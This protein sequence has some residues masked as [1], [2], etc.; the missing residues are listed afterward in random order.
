MRNAGVKARLIRCDLRGHRAKGIFIF[1]ETDRLSRV[2]RLRGPLRSPRK[3]AGEQESTAAS[4]K[5]AAIGGK[6]CCSTVA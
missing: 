6:A 1:L 2:I 5:D 4:V 3:Q